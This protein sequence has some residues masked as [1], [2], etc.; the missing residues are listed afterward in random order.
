MDDSKIT[1]SDDDH[2]IPTHQF[3]FTPINE[4]LNTTNNSLIDVGGVVICVD[5]TSTIRRRDG[6]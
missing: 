1:L 4:I 3:P 5:P 2:L 6:T